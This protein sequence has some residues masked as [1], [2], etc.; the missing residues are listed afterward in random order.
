MSSNILE[1]LIEEMDNDPWHVKLKRNWNV[2]KWSWKANLRHYKAWVTS[3]SYRKSYGD[4]DCFKT[5]REIDEE[6]CKNN[7]KCNLRKSGV[8]YIDS[9]EF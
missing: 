2:R 4:C 9:D 7:P 6:Y 5:G 1:K 8:S 3:K